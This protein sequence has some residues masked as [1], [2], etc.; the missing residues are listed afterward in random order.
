MRKVIDFNSYSRLRKMSF[1]D[2]NRWLV[3]FYAN[4]FSDGMDKAEEGIITIS[5]DDFRQ[6][7]ESVR[8]VGEKRADEIIERLKEYEKLQ[9]ERETEPDLQQNN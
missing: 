7:A 5:A 9:T 4:A 8:G 6:C 3:E 1:N 2:L